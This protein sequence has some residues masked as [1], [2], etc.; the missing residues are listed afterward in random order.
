[1]YAVEA[2]YSSYCRVLLLL[3]PTIYGSMDDARIQFKVYHTQ[4]RK[5]YDVLSVHCKNI[6]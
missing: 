4:F 3:Y 1:M 5:L 6:W 2:I